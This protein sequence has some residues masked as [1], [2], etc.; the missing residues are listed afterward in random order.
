MDITIEYCV[1]WNYEPR[2]ASLAA[3]IREQHPSANVDITPGGKGDFIVKANGRTLWD[4]LKQ[5]DEF[6]EP[7]AILS[8]ISAINW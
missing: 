7:E 1:V 6:P 4:K 8:Q 2:A 3:S 5:G